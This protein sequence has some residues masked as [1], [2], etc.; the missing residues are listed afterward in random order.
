MQQ[1]RV[2]DKIYR[3]GG[4]EF[5]IIL[6]STK[7]QDAIDIANR[8]RLSTQEY[9]VQTEAITIS[10]GVCQYNDTDDLVKLYKKLD[11]ALYLAKNNGRNRV[12]TCK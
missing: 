3:I 7:L 4:E 10:L 5:I 6:P 2:Y 11:D 12:E 8:I 9:K 1:N